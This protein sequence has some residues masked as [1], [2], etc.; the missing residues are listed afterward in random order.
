M[1]D[2]TGNT[3][4]R[5]V[6]DYLFGG[7]RAASLPIPH[8]SKPE[9]SV[10]KFNGLCV[11]NRLDLAWFYDAKQPVHNYHERLRILDCD[12]VSLA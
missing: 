6:F 12:R 9:E 4:L 5:K 10:A 8:F 11:L 2:F 1:D 7:A 3:V